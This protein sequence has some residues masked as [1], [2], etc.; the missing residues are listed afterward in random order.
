MVLTLSKDLPD[1]SER[2]SS[3][4]GQA[5]GSQRSHLEH[6]VYLE[7]SSTDD[8]VKN[9][10]IHPDNFLNKFPSAVSA[11]EEASVIREKGSTSDGSRVGRL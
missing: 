8:S 10:V 6:S 9:S 2:Y 7:Y 3:R 4:V 11:K 1:P 5:R